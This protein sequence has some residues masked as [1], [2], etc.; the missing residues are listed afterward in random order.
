MGK[1]YSVSYFKKDE[2][3]IYEKKLKIVINI[4]FTEHLLPFRGS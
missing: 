3:Q 2:K 1:K 4:F